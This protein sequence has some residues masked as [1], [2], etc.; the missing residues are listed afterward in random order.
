MA[1][2]KGKKNRPTISGLFQNECVVGECG[3]GGVTVYTALSVVVYTV[4]QRRTVFVTELT[5]R[6]YTLKGLLVHL[7]VS[8][9]EGAAVWRFYVVG[10]AV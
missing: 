6:H 2:L 3:G 10:I 9:S 4:S 8:G 7:V 1:A 5:M